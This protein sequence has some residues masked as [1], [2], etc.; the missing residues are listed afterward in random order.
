VAGTPPDQLPRIADEEM[1][2][3]QV[4]L[5]GFF[6]SVYPYPNEEGAI[7]LANVT[8][9]EAA[10]LC[11]E[12]GKRLCTELE[13]ERACK[14]PNNQNYEY[15]DRYKPSTCGTGADPRM[16]PS[17]LRVGCV[18]DFGVRDMHGGLWEW[19]RSP[20]GRGQERPLMALRGGNGIHGDLVGRCA[21][22]APRAPAS[23][24]GVIGFR[25]CAGPVNTAE[26]VVHVERKK[27]LQRSEPADKA[28]MRSVAQAVRASSDESVEGMKAFRA[29]RLW[30]WRPVGNEELVIVGGCSGLG[31]QRHCGAAVTRLGPR[32]PELLA[33]AGSGKYA[34]TVRTAEG[35]RELW[36]YGG[37]DRSHYRRMLEY[38]WGKVR[39][40]GIDR[41]VKKKSRR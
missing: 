13:W 9:D 3:E 25:C 28:V 17:G 20:W 34:P 29:S 2:G 5:N 38:L 8:Q 1:A 30:Y 31:A 6:I 12:T 11:E 27:R 40:G 36:V 22:A 10:A 24:S 21:N 26:V 32:L 23:R 7:P 33:F 4:I 15:G 14:G 37:D 41:N 35:K 19:T 18:S 16:L 39:A